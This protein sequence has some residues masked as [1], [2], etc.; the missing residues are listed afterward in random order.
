MPSW[1]H[2]V[3]RHSIT[4]LAQ[5]PFLLCSEGSRGKL[6]GR[7]G[8]VDGASWRWERMWLWERSE[9]ERLRC[10][11]LCFSQVPFLTSFIS[12]ASRS[13]LSCLERGWTEVD[14]MCS[15]ST[16]NGASYQEN[17]W[18]SK[19]QLSSSFALSWLPSSWE[20]RGSEGE[21]QQLSRDSWY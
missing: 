7:T 11:P 3:C 19:S 17:S 8:G 1:C 5:Q 2:A 12:L 18:T 21:L 13:V 14:E 20:V 6:C 10:C 9:K 4:D 15:Q 16:V